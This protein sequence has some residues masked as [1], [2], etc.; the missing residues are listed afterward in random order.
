MEGAARRNDGKGDHRLVGDSPTT[1]GRPRIGGAPG[2]TLGSRN[3]TRQEAP[4]SGAE[5]K[6][7]KGTHTGWGKWTTMQTSRYKMDRE[8]SNQKLEQKAK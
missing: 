8:Q 3:R 2:W 7:R 4:K 1:E 6:H 5:G